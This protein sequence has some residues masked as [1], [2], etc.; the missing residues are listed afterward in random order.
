LLAYAV[1]HG[2][3]VDAGNG[4]VFSADVFGAMRARIEAHIASH[5]PITL[6]TARD[7]IGTG[8]K[9]AQALLEELDRRGVTRRTGETRVLRRAQIG[10][11]GNES[12]PRI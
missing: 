11:H 9:Q 2:R 10:V 5:G 3:I 1:Q 4:V 6:A 12:S 8:R 7:V